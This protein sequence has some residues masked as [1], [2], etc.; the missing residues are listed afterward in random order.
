MPSP[1]SSCTICHSSRREIG[2]T[3]T[4]GSSSSSTFGSPTGG[5]GEA[6]LL[7]HPA[8]KL[9]CQPFGEWTKG[10]E[11]QQ[12]VENFLPRL[13]GDAAQVGVQGQVFH[14]R[15]IFIQAEL[16]WH[17]AE[18]RVQGAVVFSGSKPITLARPSSGLSNPA[19]IRIR[20]VFPRRRAPPAR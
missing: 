2:S 15:Q 7:L 12:A 9:A 3:P 10:G 14:H 11:L 20:V 1:A 6:Q 18:H 19:S 4:P 8:G 13:A 17:I 16:L 5:T